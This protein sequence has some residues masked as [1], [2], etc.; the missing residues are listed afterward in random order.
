MWTVLR[1]SEFLVAGHTS[2]MEQWVNTQT[3]SQLCA[4]QGAIEID[5][6]TYVAHLRASVHSRTDECCAQF[7]GV[8]LNGVDCSSLWR[9]DCFVCSHQCVSESEGDGSISTGPELSHQLVSSNLY[10]YRLP[11]KL[12]DWL[13]PG[14]RP[15]PW[16]QVI[17]AICGCNHK[18]T[19]TV[20]HKIISDIC[21]DDIS[22]ATFTACVHPEL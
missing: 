14:Y 2:G 11:K 19:T 17:K 8:R 4:R 7:P 20:L 21:I 12:L 6:L 15:S 1:Q 13:Y 16:H 22:D 3:Y 18:A 9:R 5:A 10:H